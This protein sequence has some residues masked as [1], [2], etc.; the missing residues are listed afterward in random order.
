[1]DA[2]SFN[3]AFSSFQATHNPLSYPEEY[4]TYKPDKIIDLQLFTIGKKNEINRYDNALL[5]VDKQVGKITNFLEENNLMNNTIIMITSDHGHDLEARHDITGHGK[6]IYNEELIV[7]AI[8][9][10]PNVEPMTVD[11][12]VS[13]I[14]FL[15]TFIDLLGYDIPK[16][17][18]GEIMREGRP[19]YF[20]TQSHKYIIGMIK[21]NTKIILDINRQ[22]IEVYD[23]SND[24]LELNN[25]YEKGEY[26]DEILQLLFWHHCQKDYYKNHKWTSWEEG[27]CSINNN[28]KI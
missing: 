16:E 6:S 18:Q 8:I 22:L 1:M 7:P 27:R 13:H 17:F 3:I 2:T 9:Y 20:V 10:L 15:P 14:D 24:P 26:T 12:R 25:I 21:N 4:A 23:L 19:I 28:F 5:Y 11:D